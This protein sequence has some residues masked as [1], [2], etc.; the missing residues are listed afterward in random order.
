MKS[1]RHF[2]QAKRDNN[3]TV[4]EENELSFIRTLMPITDERQ[5]Q[6]GK[7]RLIHARSIS[8]FLSIS[9]S[10]NLVISCICLL[11][12]TQASVTRSK[13]MFWNE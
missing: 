10:H 7:V 5:T 6:R 4:R 11:S 12:T 3:D 8:P 9:L 1:T 2:S 13:M